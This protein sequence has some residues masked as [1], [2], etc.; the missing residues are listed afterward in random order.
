MK[1]KLEPDTFQP[2]SSIE[3]AFKS[4]TLK[5]LIKENHGAPISQC[6]FCLSGSD[7][8]PK[9]LLVTTGSS[10]VIGSNQDKHL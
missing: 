10:Q 8:D 4:L 3:M 2:I 5:R 1:R 7:Q 6:F 9:N